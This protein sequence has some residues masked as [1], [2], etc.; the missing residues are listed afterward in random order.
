MIRKKITYSLAG[1]LLMISCNDQ[2][3]RQPLDS[4][5]N[6]T[7][8][9]NTADAER[10]VNDVYRFLGSDERF[11]MSCA[12]DDSYS[13]SNWPVDIQFAA[14][15]SATPNTDVFL[16]NWRY[17]Y[18]M[19]AKANDVLDNIDRVPNM[20]PTVKAELIGE[21]RFLRAFAYQQLTGLYGDVVLYTT[22]PSPEE[23]Q[24]AKTPKSEI[25]AFVINELTEITESLPIT[26]E[27]AKQGRATRGA[28]LAL[29]ARTL[30]YSGQWLEAAAAAQQVMD[31]GVYTIDNNYLSLFNGTNENSTEIILSAR[32]LENTYPNA[33]ATWIGGPSLAGWGQIVPLRGLV[34]AY[35][36]T[37]GQT[38]DV[39]PLYDPA[40]PFA[41]RDPRLGLTIVT[42][43]TPVNGVTIDVTNPNSPDALGKSNASFSGYYYRKAVPANISGEWDRSAGADVMIMRYA[44]VL[45]TYAEAKIESGQIDPSVYAAI[46]QV[47]QRTGVNMVAAT[48]ATHPDQQALR[49]L[50]RRERHV[51][52]PVE[53]NR[54]FDI[55][56]WGIAE[57]VM[58]GVAQ[59][60]FN[61]YDSSRGDFNNYVTVERRTFNPGRDYLWPIPANELIFNT[62]LTQNSGW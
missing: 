36:C 9:T 41:N 45:L 51:E 40:A 31:L 43:G 6:T 56:R 54:L 35:E 61:N 55:R 2:L 53:D 10:S 33:N 13:W 22:T 11:F 49:A 42:P 14:N 24:I 47:R 25:V 1:L 44:E 29:K 12:T 8:W 3:D 39:S 48:P 15:G 23:F 46:N 27:S 32:Y 18:Q 59:G 20:D 62:Q 5:G 38:I 16:K 50:V 21:A 30:L 26:R 4:L 37:D 57:N 34:D 17:M 58:Q 19:I 28:V 52:F 7:Y 60:I